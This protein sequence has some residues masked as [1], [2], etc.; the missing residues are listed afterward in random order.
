[1]SHLTIFV[2]LKVK[3]WN[4]QNLLQDIRSIYPELQNRYHVGDRG[5]RSVLHLL[6]QTWRWNTLLWQL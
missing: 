4:Q 2:Q 6:Y 1:M 3:C 5:I